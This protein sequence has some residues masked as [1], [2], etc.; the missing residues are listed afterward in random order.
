ML[1]NCMEDSIEGL[2]DGENTLIALARV[3]A[4][5]VDHSLLANV[6]FHR[7]D[8]CVPNPRASYW[9]RLIDCVKARFIAR[10]IF[11]G[12]FGGVR[13]QFSLVGVFMEGQFDS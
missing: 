5:G 10:F 2:S 11:A 9:Y 13:V 4:R 7:V 3:R 8:R 12:A 6:E 1:V